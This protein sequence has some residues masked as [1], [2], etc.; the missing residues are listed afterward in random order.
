MHLKDGIEARE[1]ANQYYS[2]LLSLTANTF[3]ST[4]YVVGFNWLPDSIDQVNNLTANGTNL[5]GI[6]LSK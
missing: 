3:R 6:N 1:F 2:W 4:A 5:S